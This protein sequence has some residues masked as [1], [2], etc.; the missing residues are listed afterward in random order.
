MGLREYTED[1]NTF[2]RSSLKAL[3][4]LMKYSSCL[5]EG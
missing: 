2:F 1:H 3:A 5:K 4:R